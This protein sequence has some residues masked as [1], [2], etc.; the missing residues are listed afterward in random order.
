MVYY[1]LFKHVHATAFGPEPV[2]AHESG[3]T[4]NAAGQSLCP[5][6]GAMTAEPVPARIKA[7]QYATDAR[8]WRRAVK[9]CAASF[10]KSVSIGTGPLM[11][12][13]KPACQREPRRC[14]PRALSV[15]PIMSAS[16]TSIFKR[17]G[18]RAIGTG[19]AVLG[20]PTSH[21]AGRLAR[22]V[23]VGRSA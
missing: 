9:F 13:G 11:L 2:A 1:R 18:G 8:E 22:L 7:A 6:D 3:T 15:F 23:R 10:P 12:A 5:I 19:I 14:S 4:W 16:P 20:A 21:R 17:H